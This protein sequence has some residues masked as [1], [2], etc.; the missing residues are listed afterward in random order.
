MPFLG[1]MQSIT[2]P[3]GKHNGADEL[4]RNVSDSLGRE[5]SRCTEG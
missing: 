1:T 2:G 3:V 4:N 5:M